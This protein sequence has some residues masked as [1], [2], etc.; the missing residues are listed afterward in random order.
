M[1]LVKFLYRS[2]KGYRF[3]IMLA[4]MVAVAAGQ[5]LISLRSSRSNGF[6]VRPKILVMTRPVPFLSSV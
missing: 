5:L 6:R 4:I 1:I 3:L 2:L